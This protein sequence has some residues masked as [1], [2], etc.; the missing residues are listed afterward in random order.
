MQMLGRD[1]ISSPI[2]AILELVK[3]AFDA[4]AERVI[5]EFLQAF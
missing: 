5:V 3:N 1:N 2:I 4:D